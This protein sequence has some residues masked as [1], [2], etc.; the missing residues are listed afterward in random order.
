MTRFTALIAAL[1]LSACTQPNFVGDARPIVATSVTPSTFALPARFALARVVYNS[2]APAGADEAALWSDIAHQAQGM[3][4]FTPLIATGALRSARPESLFAR[5]LEQRFDYLIITTMRPET[6]SAD[7]V[8]YHVGSGGVMATTQ[9]VPNRAGQRGFSGG[10]IR[11]PAR[12]Q[13]VTLRIAQDAQP[14]VAELLNGIAAR[15]R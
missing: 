5:A 10:A 4:T 6:A 9:V 7:I 12:L 8:V 11:N 2:V 1:V 15:Q 14:R 13:R 3:G